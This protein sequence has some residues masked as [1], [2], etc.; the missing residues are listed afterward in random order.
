MV[1]S[2]LGIAGTVCCLWVPGAARARP[3]I[4]VALLL[5]LASFVIPLLLVLG[6][7]L[8]Y[9]AD[10]TAH[11][12]LLLW[13]SPILVVAAWAFF[14]FYLRRLAQYLKGGLAADESLLILL[15]GAYLLVLPAVI[16]FLAD[17]FGVFVFLRLG[18]FPIPLEMVLPFYLLV[19][20]LLLVLRQLALIGSLRQLIHSRG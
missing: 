15:R 7:V 9:L 3:F 6:W 20:F 4:L 12:T 17:Q 1:V 16:F 8:G 14:L 19:A 5:D 2:M 18:G 10:D 11:F 13:T